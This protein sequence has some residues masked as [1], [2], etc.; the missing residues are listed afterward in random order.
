MKMQKI[1]RKIKGDR[2]EFGNRQKKLKKNSE[3]FHNK[4][5]FC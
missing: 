2:V 3:N 1:E 4:F 5:D